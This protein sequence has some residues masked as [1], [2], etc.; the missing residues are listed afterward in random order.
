MLKIWKTWQL[1]TSK[2]TELPREEEEPIEL[3]VGLVHISH[4]NAML[5]CGLLRKLLMWKKKEKGDR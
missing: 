4:L 3:M 5:K 1:I 2:P